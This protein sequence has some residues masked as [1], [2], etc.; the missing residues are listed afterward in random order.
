MNRRTTRLLPLLLCASL[1]ACGDEAEAR[2]ADGV[3]F[4]TTASGAVVVRSPAEG[5]WE[6]G[7]AWRL[8]EEL[9]I[10][11]VDGD[12]P[13]MFGEVSGVAVDPLGRIWV[14]ERQAAEVRVFDEEGRHIRTVGRMRGDEDGY[15]WV[16][17]ARE[18]NAE[19]T[20]LD[21]FDPESRYLG[22]ITTGEEI[23]SNRP[24]VVRGDRLYTVVRDEM[25]VPYV[26]RYRIEGKDAAA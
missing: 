23:S 8:V 13:E 3:T 7:E 19:G 11:A 9:R 4:D 22:R 5:V 2:R 17:P 14:V 6:E 10:G 12:G 18:A 26:V 15:L 25:D 16:W 1:A 21:V 24:F 20:A